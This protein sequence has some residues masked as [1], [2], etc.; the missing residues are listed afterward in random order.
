MTQRH[1]PGEAH[2]PAA[3][4]GGTKSVRVDS[5]GRTQDLN[6]ALKGSGFAPFRDERDL[7]L[8][9]DSVCSRFGKI[10]YLKI[11][12]PRRG[13]SLRCACYLRLNSSA[14]ETALISAFGLSQYAG[15][16]QFFADVDEG[17]AN[18]AGKRSAGQF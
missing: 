3:M 18:H 9:I 4:P 5:P 1:P 16:I 10:T 14:A 6:L 12:P 7:E 11:L 15:T 17:W 2:L 13:S 8:A